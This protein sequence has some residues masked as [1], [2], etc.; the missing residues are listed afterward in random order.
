MKNKGDMPEEK[1][2]LILEFVKNNPL[3]SSKEIHDGVASL[4]ALATVKRGLKGLIAE[5]LIEVE[6]SGRGSKYKIGPVY[7][8]FYPI[9][10]DHYF[11]QEID[12]R[13]VRK[14]FNFLL[15]S[16]LLRDTE[17]FK[18]YEL[19]DL[20]L[21]QNRFT[22][23]KLKLSRAA[24]AKELERLSIDLSWKSSQ[25][26]GNTYSLLETERLL[27]EKETAAGK[28]K[29]EAIMLLNH[30][31][32]IDFIINNPSDLF[33]LDLLKIE[34]LHSILISG[35]GIESGIRTTQ[36]GITGTNYKPLEYEQAIRKALNH[37]CTLVNHK[38]SVFEKALLL[39]VLTSYIQPFV[40]GNKRLARI[41]SNAALIHHSYCPLSYR[42]VD[43]LDFKKALLLFY[44]QNNL[45]AIKST[46]M[47][48]Y[49]FAVNTYF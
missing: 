28:T 37:L 46:F 24:Y 36:V 3:L 11:S 31:E 4:M 39:L 30:K 10:L 35:L 18:E 6:G 25:I 13:E 49:E 38:T 40:D 9:D 23:K 29:D 19:Q 1:H 33:P 15:I 20:S 2:H 5:K 26:E 48:Q 14:E 41:L 47:E 12:Q 21:L 44:E 16:N 27:K 32:A 45:T 42:T 34:K 17:L 22:E 43:T 7:E 8:L